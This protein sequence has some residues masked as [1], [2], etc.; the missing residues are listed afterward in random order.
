TA[1][2]LASVPWEECLVCPWRCSNG[3]WSPACWSHSSVGYELRLSRIVQVDDGGMLVIGNLVTPGRGPTLDAGVWFVVRHIDESGF[4]GTWR[5][6]STIQ[7][8]PHGYFCAL[9]RATE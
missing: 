7:P 1:A 6:G 9:R 4:S 8:T 2:N 5:D 3:S